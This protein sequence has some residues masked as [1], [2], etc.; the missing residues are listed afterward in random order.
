MSYF[1]FVVACTKTPKGWQSPLYDQPEREVKKMGLKLLIQP[2]AICMDGCDLA[3]CVIHDGVSS[4]R[5]FET[6]NSTHPLSIG[7]K[8]L[9]LLQQDNSVETFFTLKWMDEDPSGFSAESKDAM[10]VDLGKAMIPEKELKAGIVFFLRKERKFGARWIK[11]Y[12]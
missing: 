11:D 3:G 5:L 9:R 7:Q 12:T 4:D 8:V 10:E 1:L 6:P 2:A